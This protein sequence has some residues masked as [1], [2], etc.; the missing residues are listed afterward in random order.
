[1]QQR[2]TISNYLNGTIFFSPGPTGH[3]PRYLSENFM[4][5]A[6]LQPFHGNKIGKLKT[7]HQIGISIII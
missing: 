6:T 3:P 1:M 2:A 4:F 5:Q 7:E